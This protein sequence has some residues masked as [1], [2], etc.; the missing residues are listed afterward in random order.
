MLRAIAIVNSAFLTGDSWRVEKTNH[1][2]CNFRRSRPRRVR[3]IRS[4]DWR[5]YRESIWIKH[6]ASPCPRG[7]WFARAQLGLISG[8]VQHSGD[9]QP[10]AHR[11]TAKEHLNPEDAEH[12]D[13]SRALSKRT[14]NLLTDFTRYL[15]ASL[16]RRA[17]ALHLP[18]YMVHR[19]VEIELR[20]A[21]FSR[22]E[23]IPLFVERFNARG[24]IKFYQPIKNIDETNKSC[25]KPTTNWIGRCR[26]WM[27]AM[28]IHDSKM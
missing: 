10:R 4:R 3:N 21:R 17:S 22:S 12:G 11:H 25:Y 6:P 16:P 26:W 20:R 8:T 7:S 2:R 9:F 23:H 19:A 13:K 24:S 15:S 18:T 5:S 27:N 1:D 28:A 14:D